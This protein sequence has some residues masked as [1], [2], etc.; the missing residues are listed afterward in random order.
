MI[1]LNRASYYTTDSIIFAIFIMILI[2]MSLNAL[3]HRRRLL[4]IIFL[5]ALVVSIRNIPEFAM[6]H[7]R[8]TV[9]MEGPINYFA[10][11][12]RYNLIDV[13][14][15]Y[16][17]ILVLEEKNLEGVEDVAVMETE[18]VEEKIYGRDDL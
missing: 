5:W 17:Q 8:I 2:T 6:P 1:E 15:S 10:L 12:E 14:D 4:S 3:V 18:G 16:E 13:I 9:V 11:S 7:T